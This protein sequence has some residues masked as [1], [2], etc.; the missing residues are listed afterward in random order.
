MGR[1]T[2][3]MCRLCR[4][5]GEKLFLKGDRCFT[6]KCAIDRRRRSPG[7]QRFSRRRL[8][9]Y[10]VRLVEKQKLRN[11]YG[12][13]EAQFARYVA[14]AQE[15]PGVTSLYLLQTLECRLDNVVFRLGFADSRNAA[16][17]T[18]L[19]GHI[20]INGKRVDV[21][22]YPVAPGDAVA[23]SGRSKEREFVK[24]RMQNAPKRPLPTWLSL[25]AAS[26]E[27][28]VLSIPKAEEIEAKVDPRLIIEFYSR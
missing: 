11:M 18:V 1:Y 27:G 7:A 23:W 17:Q 9:D 28:K 15:E 3:P 4:K 12:L 2:G 24:A 16:R 26:V 21:P 20:L 10:G 22:S 6:P 8:S 5:A 14:K 13:L 19:H 25:D